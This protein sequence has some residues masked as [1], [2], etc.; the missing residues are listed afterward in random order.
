MEQILIIDDDIALCTMMRDYF[1]VQDMSLTMCHHGVEGL[2]QARSGRFDLILLDI[3]LPGMEGFDL[4]C[5][6]RRSSDVKVI[7]LTSRGDVDDRIRGLEI[8]ADDYVPKPFNPRELVA[9]IRSILRRGPASSARTSANFMGRVSVHGFD[10]DTAARKA[11]YRGKALALTETEFALLRLLLGSPGVVLPREELFVRISQR[12]FHPLDRSLD[13]LVSRLRRKLDIEDN[14]GLAIRTI[15][16]SGYVFDAPRNNSS[17]P[18]TSRR[19]SSQSGALR[20]YSF[21]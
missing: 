4:L 16:N 9:R 10:I 21:G 17:K 6:L 1:S 14:P 11:L 7:L 2:E 8:G 18:G 12:P 15:R 13:M 20:P 5:L 3:M 19:Y